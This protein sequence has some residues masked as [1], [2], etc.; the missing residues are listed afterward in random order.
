MHFNYIVGIHTYI[1]IYI[2]L[3][4][5]LLLDYNVFRIYI[6]QLYDFF[7]CSGFTDFKLAMIVLLC[8]WNCLNQDIP[9]NWQS[10][11]LL[12]Y[13]FS[14]FHSKL[15]NQLTGIIIFFSKLPRH[16]L[17]ILQNYFCRCFKWLI[18]L[19]DDLWGEGGSGNNSAPS[20]PSGATPALHILFL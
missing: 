17:K 19:M 16:I 10:R 2:C 1:C 4:V 13:S 3:K 14:L 7:S 12:D 8:C 5:I 11:N 9:N 20:R 15:I 18:C 6:F